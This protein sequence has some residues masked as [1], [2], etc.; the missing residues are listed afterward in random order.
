MSSKKFAPN[1]IRRTLA[2]ASVVLMGITL[3]ACTS[4][5]NDTNS[6]PSPLEAL[7]ERGYLLYG[8]NGERPYNWM[9]ESGEIVGSEIEIARA[10][11]SELGIENVQG[12]AMNFDSFIPALQ[13]G[14]VDTVMPIF[15]KPE[16]CESL[17]F[18]EPHLIEGQSIIVP[19]GNPENITSWESIRENENVIGVIA[20][21]T[22]DSFAVEYGIPESK[23]VRFGD[24]TNMRAGM[25]AGRVDAI[26]EASSTIREIAN[27]IGDDFE[28]LEEWVAPEGY[29]FDFYAAFAFRPGADDIAE[30]WNEAL[31][32]LLADGTINEITKPYGFSAADRPN[33]DS[34]NLSELCAS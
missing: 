4:A 6:G 17:P 30:A 9:D 26:I 25:Q 24:T 22:P 27:S 8:F 1:V 16:R 2:G 32:K 13:G 5:V 29:S 23:I 34:L 14:L 19:R 7:Q 10:V 20:G 11:A 21:T 31:M 33:D 15:V 18:S 3:A 28:R 12:V